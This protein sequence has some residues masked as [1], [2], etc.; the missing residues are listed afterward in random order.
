MEC[1]LDVL[2]LDAPPFCRPE[3]WSRRVA[4]SGAFGRQDVCPHR[5]PRM[6]D[7]VHP[8]STRSFKVD[9]FRRG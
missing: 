7:D 3:A 9:V 1:R 4:T 8:F 6:S 5:V 2:K